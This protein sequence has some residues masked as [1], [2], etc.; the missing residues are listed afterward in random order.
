[1][2]SAPAVDYRN[3][4]H[5]R[6]AE[7]CS[8]HTGMPQVS[9]P[10]IGIIQSSTTQISTLQISILQSSKT[11]FSTTQAALK[12]LACFGVVFDDQH[13][14]EVRLFDRPQNA[15]CRGLKD[16]GTKLVGSSNAYCSAWSV[17][18]VM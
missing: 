12:V 17:I 16:L 15:T 1:M 4:G 18:I 6:I 5:G 7:E 3:I 10:Q 8:A 9:N 13:V 14:H 2:L 11:K